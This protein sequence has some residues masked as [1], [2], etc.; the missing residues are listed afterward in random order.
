MRT[1]L[2]S[3]C[4]MLCLVVFAIVG[5]PKTAAASCSGDVCGCGTDAA[6]CRAECPPVGDPNHNACISECNHESIQCSVCCCCEDACP[7]YCY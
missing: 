4:V 5:A 1:K 6:E 3:M 7:L 2:V